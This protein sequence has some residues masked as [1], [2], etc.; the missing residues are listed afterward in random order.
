VPEDSHM[1]EVYEDNEA[2]EWPIESPQVEFNDDDESML[3]KALA[4]SL[5]E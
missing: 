5:N 4:D 1:E 3:A 2:E